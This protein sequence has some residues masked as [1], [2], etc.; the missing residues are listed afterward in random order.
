MF[1]EKTVQ[2]RWLETSTG[3]FPLQLE[4]LRMNQMIDQDSSWIKIISNKECV[5]S[6]M[7]MR[8][9]FLQH[10]VTISWFYLKS[11][12]GTAY[13]WA[14]Q[15]A[16]TIAKFL[17]FFV[18]PI[19]IEVMLSEGA[20][21][22][23]GLMLASVVGALKWVRTWFT[24]LDFKSRRVSFLIHFA[25][26]CILAVMFRFMETV[27]LDIFYLLESVWKYCMSSLPAILALRDV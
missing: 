26:P 22:W 21:V 7:L 17:L 5:L 20:C 24:F 16:S 13:G 6:M 15:V 14:N 11:Y 19:V 12:L 3:S 1:L 4:E 25:I 9:L 2:F 18:V 27:T 23:I 10:F 8:K